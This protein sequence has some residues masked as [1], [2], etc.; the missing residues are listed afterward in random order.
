MFKSVDSTGTGNISVKMFKKVL[1][2]CQLKLDNEQLYHLLETL[3][4]QLSGQI[5]YHVFL[6]VIL[7]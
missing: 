2:H 4:P 5:N 6:N 3:D 1:N 7:E